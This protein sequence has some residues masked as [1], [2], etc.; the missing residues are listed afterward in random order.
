MA[1]NESTTTTETVEA[2]SVEWL[3]GLDAVA[4]GT[5]TLTGHVTGSGTGTV[6]TSI[7]SGVITNTMI[8]A[9]A[10]IS[11]SKIA[12]GTVDDTEF[13]YLNGVTSSIQTQFSGKENSIAAGTTGQYWRGDKSWQTLDKS[14]VGLGNVDNTS[15]AN[16]PISSATQ[17]A[18]NAKE[19]TITA[20]TTSQYWRGDKSWQTF[21]LDALTDVVITTPSNG[22]ILSYNGT[23]WVNSAASS[24][25]VTGSGTAG[26]VAYWDGTSSITSSSAFTY[27]ATNADLNVDG[28]KIGKISGYA[29]FADS[30]NYDITK[31]AL[32]QIPASGT[33]INT[34]SII[35]FRKNNSDTYGMTFD[36]TYWNIS[37]DSSNK[38]LMNCSS[39]GVFSFTAYG[40]STKFTF[41][42]AVEVPDS[43][44][45]AGWNGST[46]VPTRNAVYDKIESI[47]LDDLSGVTV[48][49]PTTGQVLKYNGTTWVNDTDA[50]GGGGSVTGS[51]TANE[52]AYWT[53][54]SSLGTLS[55]ATYPSLTELSYVKGVTSAI[56]TQINNKF[57]LPSLT[58]GSVLFSD[59]STIAQDNS[60]FFWDDTNNR[61]GIRTNS[62]QN[63]LH[64]V[65][66]TSLG[67]VRL[68]WD[69][70]YYTR[71]LA[72][73]LGGLTIAPSHLGVT[74]F[75][76][77]TPQFTVS[78]DGSNQLTTSVSATGVVTFDA[79]GTS[80]K[81]VFSDNVDV[82][83]DIYTTGNLEL[84]NASDTTLSRS[85]AGVLAVEGVVI[86]SISSTNTLTNKSLQDST[87]WFVDDADSTKKMQFQLSGI[88]TATTRTLTVPNVNG[89]IVTT[90]DTGTVTSTMMTT[91]GVSA[92]SYTNA[93][94][95]VDASGRITAA[96][97]GSSGG[98]ATI[99]IGST[100][101]SGTVGSVLFVGTGPVLQQD[102]A[103]LFWDDTNNRL[104]I[105]TA[106][107]GYPLDVVGQSRFSAQMGIENTAPTST[108]S[109]IVS[110]NVS[111][112]YFGTNL[113]YNQ[114][115]TG[116]IYPF[117]AVVRAQTTGSNG[118]MN[119][120][121]LDIN[122][123]NGAN[124]T[125]STALNIINSST[126]TST[127]TT[128]TTMVAASTAQSTTT[129][130]R[131]IDLLFASGSSSTITNLYFYRAQ[132][133]GGGTGGTTTTL[134]GLRLDGWT[135][136]SGTVTT[137][138]GI[139]IDTTV[140][141]GTTAYGIY[142]LLTS[143]S[144]HVGKLGIGSGTT[145]PTA[146]LQVRDT[147]EQ[148]R[149]EYDASNYYTV[150]VGTTGAVAYDAIGT[151]PKFTFSDAVEVPNEAYGS[152][153]NGK[154]EVP[155]K[156]AVYDRLEL[157]KTESFVIAASDETTAITAGTNKVKFRIP[158]A[159]TVTAVRASLSTAQTSG[160]IFTVDINEAGTSILSTKLTIDNTE[161]T[162][163]TAATAAVISDTSLADDAE[164]SVDVDQIGDGT[165]KGL[166]VVIIGFRT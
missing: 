53:G 94:I 146:R 128:M 6:T 17:T 32:L 8:S 145:A 124:V 108:S 3:K 18:L 42:S 22:Q 129:T 104:G 127:V 20:G 152:G 141:V 154:T 111:G 106:T 14:A 98:S 118:Q 38:M 24:G 33:Y 147:T 101:T 151:S 46:A 4:S 67:Q 28:A 93:N 90:G 36:G 142:S 86:P 64:V 121:V 56:Q 156:D 16:K 43:A 132:W 72:G 130:L 59:G 160:N 143:P 5:T 9:S 21:N 80:P 134:S 31:Y 100:V 52:L 44:Y 49:S 120:V 138:Y 47:T 68:G 114:T 150:T 66:A 26:R 41:N 2:F 13:G 37:Y 119:G 35:Y 107:P 48:T 40:T 62:P 87:T 148:V 153:W 79:V 63:A 54:S 165:A 166:K 27:D 58:S 158:Y 149:V 96:S 105:A 19:P 135:K 109:L 91:T 159:F 10:A 30:A 60:N 11:A 81:F 144:H 34:D 92:A 85:S 110:K 131:G 25:G 29:G 113:T 140:G 102:N 122:N 115:G 61:L 55:T 57:T 1:L 70:T 69:S 50:T 7:A 112:N 74:V 137:S 71:L 78:Y 12:G 75:T 155:T 76:P 161:S 125:A 133:T 99:S 136:N 51:G 163:T 77:A 126:A 73:S 39:T 97:N 84:G 116:N 123:Q 65:A 162:S 82:S 88:T 83:G 117:Y 139:Y 103:N 15:D 95:T 157:M 45:G 89:T 164:I 23:N